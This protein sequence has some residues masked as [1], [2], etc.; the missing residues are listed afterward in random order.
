MASAIEINDATF[1]AEVLQSDQPVLVDFSAAWCGPCKQLTPIIEELAQEYDG[2]VKIGTVD[3]DASQQVAGT[4]G[5]MSVP[6]VLLFKG[7]EQVDSIVGL[8]AKSVYKS[9]IDEL[10]TG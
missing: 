7:G 9:K 5:I 1:E 4:Y 8:N 3:V 2:R 6:T 10:L